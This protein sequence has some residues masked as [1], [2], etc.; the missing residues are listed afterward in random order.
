[1]PILKAG[2][3]AE[4]WNVYVAL[5]FCLLEEVFHWAEPANKDEEDEVPDDEV[6]LLIGQAWRTDTEG[7]LLWILF[8]KVRDDHLESITGEVLMFLA[9]LLVDLRLEIL[10]RV[11]VGGV[12]ND[13]EEEEESKEEE[14][15]DS[16]PEADDPDYHELE[17]SELGGSGPDESGSPSEQSNEE[18]G[19]ATRL[20]QALRWR[21]MAHRW[22][23]IAR[24][25]N[26]LQCSDSDSD[27]R[28]ERTMPIAHRWI[29]MAQRWRAM[30]QRWNIDGT[31]IA[32]A[33]RWNSN[34]EGSDNDSDS[35][36]SD[37]DG[38]PIEMAQR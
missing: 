25:W 9:Q 12:V 28:D 17:E 5:N 38:A 8:E 7:E 18:D 10:S 30:A 37:N 31:E 29:T 13:A 3:W 6:E 24:R 27:G 23:A 14:E 19:L 20:S 21:A 16:E 11:E 15:E 36:G 35:D 4:W 26:A 1:M 32:M 22:R 33:Q 2:K 34:S